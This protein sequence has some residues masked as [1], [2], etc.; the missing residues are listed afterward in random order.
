VRPDNGDKTNDAHG[1]DEAQG[2]IRGRSKPHDQRKGNG[3]DE[4]SHGL[5]LE[6]PGAPCDRLTR[7]DRLGWIQNQFEREWLC[8]VCCERENGAHLTPEHWTLDFQDQMPKT[9]REYTMFFARPA[10]GKKAVDRY[11]LGERSKLGGKPDWLQYDATPNCESCRDRMTFVAQIDS[12][13]MYTKQNPHAIDSI[14]HRSK[15]QYM[16]GDVG[17]L[18]V[19]YCFDCLKTKSILQF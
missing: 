3:H 9:L 2:D 19:F 15:Q 14:R 17:M 8:H 16:F 18:Y 11:A 6:V 4:Y 10:K 13:E 12:I 1:S 7:S 5:V